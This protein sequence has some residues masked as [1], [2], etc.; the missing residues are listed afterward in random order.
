MAMTTRSVSAAPS[1][2]LIE[3][4]RAELVQ[5]YPGIVAPRFF[6]P[7]SPELPT[8]GPAVGRAARALG[9]ELMPHQQLVSDV[10]G[11]VLPDGRMHYPVVVVL[12]PRRGGK[13]KLLLPTFLQRASS[14]RRAKCW[15]TAQ[16]GGDA[17]LTLREEW[18]PALDPL[19]SRG[20]VRTRLS[21]G[22]EAF[23]VPRSAGRV[24]IFAPTRKALHGQDADVVGVDELWAF[25]RLQGMALMQAIKPAQLTR[26]DRQLWLISAGGDDSSEWLLDWRELGRA[27][28]GPGQGVAYF[29]WHPPVE[30]ADDG[31]TWQLASDVDLDDPAVW[32]DTHPAVGHTAT[33]DAL[34]S[35]R[36][37]FGKDE[38]DRAY[39]NVFQTGALARVLPRVAWERNVSD[40]AAVGTGWGTVVTFDAAPE[41][42][43]ASVVLSKL[44]SSSGKVVAELVDHGP[45][46]GWTAARVGQLAIEHGARIVADGK[47]ASTAITAELRR[48]GHVVDELGTSNVA[49]AADALLAALLNDRVA[50]RSEPIMDAAAASAAKRQLG[51]GWAFT[52]R[53][54]TGDV[55]PVVALSFGV[56]AASASTDARPIIEGAQLVAS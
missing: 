11:E 10:A 52:R 13:T 5:A 45:G 54:S 49:D 19:S 20:L 43:S 34:S 14:I 37:V 36:D 1:R 38:F 24:A 22:S 55:T 27:L 7:R 18:L 35:D 46:T 33:L 47:G 32:A 21:N 39:L 41:S 6:T 15:Y 31:V 9:V 56:Q 12:M 50:I 2:E 8:L 44:D 26:P 30:L 40:T 42:S 51:D 28:T 17:G 25:D 16:T 3:Q 29:E 23:T 53:G 48:M 4:R